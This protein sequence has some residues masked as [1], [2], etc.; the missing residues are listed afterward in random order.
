MLTQGPRTKQTTEK[1]KK[2]NDTD[3]PQN[4]EKMFDTM[5]QNEEG[6]NKNKE[7][8]SKDKQRVKKKK[9][10]KMFDTSLRKKKVR[11]KA[12]D[13]PKESGRRHEKRKKVLVH[14]I[15]F[16]SSL[17]FLSLVVP[18]IIHLIM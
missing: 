14:C 1:K 17:S 7:L 12:L 18:D 2:Y 13:E 4:E 5:T 16:I 9:E 15:S 6:D 3:K 11:H 8:N 10:E